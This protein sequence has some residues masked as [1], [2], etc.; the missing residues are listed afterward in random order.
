MEGYPLKA[1]LVIDSKK[2][3]ELGAIKIEK[4]FNNGILSAMS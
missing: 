1:T 4:R 2:M 3:M